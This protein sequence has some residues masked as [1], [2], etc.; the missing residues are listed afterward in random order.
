MFDEVF[1]GFGDVTIH[2]RATP[3]PRRQDAAVAPSDSERGDDA[4]PVRDAA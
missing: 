4:D 3:A 1:E 2:Q